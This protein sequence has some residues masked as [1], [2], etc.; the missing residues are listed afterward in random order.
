MNNIKISVTF[1]FFAIFILSSCVGDV[2]GERTSKTKSNTKE[3]KSANG[4]DGSVDGKN[5]FKDLDTTTDT[6]TVTLAKGVA[7]IRHVI[8]PFDG[9]FQSKLT[10]PRN[11]KGNFY[12]SGLNMASLN[13]K[14]V[15][16]K[17]N[18]GRDY[19][20]VKLVATVGRAPGLTPQVDIDVLIIDASSSPFKD[21]R[22]PYDLYDYNDYDTDDNKTKDGVESGTP[23][24]DPRNSKLYCRG[25]RIEDDPT[26]VDSDNNGLCDNAADKCYYAYAKV[27][28]SGLYD[29]TNVT[30]IPSAMQVDIGGNGYSSETQD[31]ALTKCL[32]DN[33][34]VDNLK[35]V[36]GATSVI[37]GSVLGGS[38]TVVMSSGTYTYKGPYRTINQSAWEISSSAM[39]SQVTSTAKGAGLF[40]LNMAGTSSLDP[41]TGYKS[42]IF[43]RA[44]QVS[45]KSDVEY[46]GSSGPF[47]S[48]R[49]LTSLTSSGTSKY[50]DGCNLRISSLYE[51]LGTMM[52]SCNVT[53]TIEIVEMVSGKEVLL[54]SSS[55]VK[56]QLTRD[57][58]TNSEGKEV[59]Y[60]A[61]R[62]CNTSKEC[63][64]D[65]CCYNNRCWSKDFVSQCS[66]EVEGQGRIGIGEKCTKDFDCI[67]LCCNTSLGT[68]GVHSNT[69]DSD[70]DP[71]YCSK[72]P[73]QSC[74][75]QEWCRV[76]NISKCDIYFM[77]YDQETG[78]KTC[79]VRCFNVP[80]HGDCYNGTCYPP[81]VPAK[82]TF[83]PAKPDCT[84]A[85]T[86]PVEI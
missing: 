72:S 84:K 34:N 48:S 17:F 75:S 59:L 62:S 14:F 19:E 6:T 43:P 64:T 8:D 58:Q 80:T 15:Y 66:D 35:G 39:F 69:D 74:V 49:T 81:V 29:S 9:S 67:S 10:I 23:V 7:E 31:V 32:P 27:V 3:N 36:V 70:E 20:P 71:V 38:N 52:S 42:F 44:G 1:L 56:L 25:L 53:A 77:G 4:N 57:S 33:N 46:Y 82:P 41:E 73:G 24:V 65:E 50:M 37:A 61:F 45:L 30:V 55:D 11:F 83:D 78:S 21:M 47:D 2:G 79:A 26:F 63:G 13:E 76:D 40:Q 16:V 5:S 68:C 12:V 18:F 28:D 60:S 85:K 22:L 54:S 86:L 51:E